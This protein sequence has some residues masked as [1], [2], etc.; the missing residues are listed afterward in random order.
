MCRSTP[1]ARHVAEQMVGHF[2]RLIEQQRLVITVVEARRSG[3]SSSRIAIAEISSH[4]S[5]GFAESYLARPKPFL[6]SFLLEESL[7]SSPDVLLDPRQCAK[8]NIGAGLAGVVL[9]FVTSDKVF[10]SEVPS[11]EAENAI[12]L[13]AISAH[14]GYNKWISFVEGGTSSEGRILGAGFRK[15]HNFAT[16]DL[17][18]F[19]QAVKFSLEDRGVYALRRHQLDAQSLYSF[20]GMSLVYEP[21]VFRFLPSEQELL[22]LAL[23]GETDATSAELL[24]L[25]LETIKKRWRGIFEHTLI[26]MPTLYVDMDER[27]GVRG[28]ERRQ[29]IIN[30]CRV[31]PQEL[32]PHHLRRNVRHMT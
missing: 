28:P 23:A 22:E 2:G 17:D 1:I 6:T 3:E 31:H 11:H 4:T 32:K 10:N 14:R 26:E 21:P 8:A 27:Q 9:D 12:R 13:A 18:E 24:G 20:A 29:K 7:R 30:Y 19:S 5:L 16:A 15:V 25:S